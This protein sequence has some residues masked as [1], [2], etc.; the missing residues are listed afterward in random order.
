MRLG[1]TRL[2]ATESNVV[3]WEQIGDDEP[4]EPE[5][6]DPFTAPVVTFPL[7]FVGSFHDGDVDDYY[8]FTLN[9][10]STLEITLDWDQVA[11]DIDLLVVDGA[12]TMFVCSFQGATA[13]KPEAATCDLA[14]GEYVLWVNDFSAEV[15]GDLSLVSYRLI[16]EIP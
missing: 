15:L 9:E 4:G 3:V 7:D 6:D 1:G 12:F 5:N 10:F 11:K 13:Q 14:A 2:G 16:A 8:R